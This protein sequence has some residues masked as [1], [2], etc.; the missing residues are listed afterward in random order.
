LVELV[1]DDGVWSASVL[2]SP[3]PCGAQTCRD[4]GGHGER[5]ECDRDHRDQEAPKTAGAAR[6]VVV[7]A[8][9]DDSR[10]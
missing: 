10:R 1:G 4:R 5:A 3:W 6:H 7:L 9:L 2:L 8:D